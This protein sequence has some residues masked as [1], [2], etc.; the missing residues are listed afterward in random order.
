M[1]VDVTQM[2]VRWS[3]G[4]EDAID[5]LLQAL[6]VE[7]KRLVHVRLSREPVGH[8]LE[9]TGL[10]HD[11]YLR[12]IDI[13]R[14]QWK[15]RSHFLKMAS[16]TMWRMLI[17]HA[18]DRNARKRG[19]G[20]QKEALKEEM[21]VSEVDAERL[22]EFDDAIRRLSEQYPAQSQ[23]IER[24]YFRGLTLEEAGE[25][26]HISPPPVMRDV[27]F[28]EAWLAREWRGSIGVP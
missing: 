26:L 20:A 5:T 22:P 3:D 4:D 18:R 17:D 12:L 14:V 27:C 9:T 16:R 10:V 8:T 25:A 19:G 24:R 21:L 6:Y 23:A 11:A 15:D 13:K 28:A 1:S 2:L 7:L